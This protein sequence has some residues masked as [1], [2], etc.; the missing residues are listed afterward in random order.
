M[1]RTTAKYLALLA[2]ATILFHWKTLLTNQFTTI[3]GS[4]AVDQTYGWLHFWVNSVWHGHAPLWDPYEFG[5]RPFAGEMQTAAYYPVRLLFALMPLNRNGMVSPRFYHEYLAFARFL[6]ACFMFGLLREFRRSH[7]AALIGAMAFSM[8]GLV[9]RLPWPHYMESCTWIPAVFLF[10]LRALRAEGR[11]RALAEA[12]LAGV[13]IGMS[14]LTGGVQFSMMQGIGVVTAVIC[15]GVAR[16]PLPS[17]HG[18]SY[19]AGLAAIVAVIV[20]VAGG[21]GAPQL[22]TANEYSHLS[23]RSITGGWFPMADK[24]PYDRMDRGMWPQSI[25]TGLFPANGQM[26]GGEG[27]PYYIGVF[28]LLLAVTGIWKCWSN[29]WVRYFSGLALVAF[30]YVLGEYSPLY[31]MLYALVP[32]L[33]MVREPSRFIYLVSFALAVLAAFG[34]DAVLDGAG[35]PATW[36]PAKP[37]LKWIAIACI[38]ALFVP[39]IFTQ[40]AL[41]IWPCL[42]ILLILASCAWF[43]RLTVRPASPTVLVMLAAFILFD[44]S[45]FNWGAANRN[46]V[47]K[48][49][50]RYQQTL[51]LRPAAEF[52]KAQPGLNR[53][54]VQMDPEPNVGDIYGVQSLWGGGATV[55]DDYARLNPHEDL[56]NVRYRI[57]PATAPDPGPVYQDALWKVYEDPKAYPRAWLVHQTIMASSDDDAF[58]RIDKGGTDF[59]NVAILEKPLPRKLDASASGDSVRFRSYEADSM[60]MDV[61]TAGT[62]LLVLSEVYYPGWKASV[63]GKTA[64]IHKVDGALRGVVVPAGVSRVVLEYVPAS[65]Y[66]GAGL[67][68]ITTICV[69]LGWILL[70]HK[71]FGHRRSH[72]PLQHV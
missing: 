66:A 12:G 7:F 41:G 27:W 4:E 14:I 71:P 69:L 30:L 29:L 52:V 36:A 17:A 45:L 56:F 22:F 3:V 37:F 13:C 8:G 38:V 32:Y 5:G 50:D 2:L 68:L 9:G 31:G 39:G 23:L 20:V 51:T 70:W 64:E 26:S 63:N 28:P 11:G 43:L 65:Y 34:L 42:S 33:W 47:T 15:Y 24:I 46:E 40:L 6:G 44:L 35:Q 54:R 1:T 25:I 59:H 10:L 57:R 19:W 61:K 53:V 48:S 18:R 67:S 60:S 21:I 49:G 62:G 58:Q 55:I 72:H 16:L